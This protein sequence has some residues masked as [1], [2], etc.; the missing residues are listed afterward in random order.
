MITVD[1][2]FIIENILDLIPPANPLSSEIAKNEGKF[3]E[4]KLTLK[5]LYN[6][7]NFVNKYIRKTDINKPALV[8]INNHIKN[9]SVDIAENFSNSVIER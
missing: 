6:E 4:T 9:Y 1:V 8:K 7:M 5:P 3:D 2:F